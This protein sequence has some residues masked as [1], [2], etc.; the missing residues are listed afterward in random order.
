MFGV[1]A[2]D[3]KICEKKTIGKDQVAKN[4]FSKKQRRVLLIFQS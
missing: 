4:H 1:S 2:E 3:M